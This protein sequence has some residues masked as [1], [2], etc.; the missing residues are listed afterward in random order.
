[1]LYIIWFIIGILCLFCGVVNF[2]VSLTFIGNSTGG[3]IF[4]F[5]L[6]CIFIFAGILSF[7][8]FNT[9]K[10][11][12]NP[13]NAMS[14]EDYGAYGQFKHTIGLS[15]PENILCKLHLSS[16]G[17]EI[18]GNGVS[19]NLPRNRIL[20]ITIKSEEEIQKQFVSSAGGAVAGGILFGPLGAMIGGR[21]KE[22][23]TSKIK[24]YLIFTYEKDNNPEYIAFD[25]TGTM[26]DT[27]F[28]TYFR[29]YMQKGNMKVDL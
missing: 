8:K 28:I 4:Q 14:P 17:L 16:Q 9:R 13:K 7:K 25:T 10:D 22:K 20:D 11:P 12:K 24:T 21:T 15:M 23:K 6:A 5:I 29:K 18:E 2:I 3:F 1:M 26:K 19:F 27:K